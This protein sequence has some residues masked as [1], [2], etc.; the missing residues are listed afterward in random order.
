MRSVAFLVPVSLFVNPFKSGLHSS[1]SCTIITEDPER[2][3][4]VQ[5][6]SGSVQLVSCLQNSRER[7][8]FVAQIFWKL[9]EKFFGTTGRT[10]PR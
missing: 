6:A 9:S 2:K 4:L 8:L 3:C 7:K 1:D 10:C 5:E